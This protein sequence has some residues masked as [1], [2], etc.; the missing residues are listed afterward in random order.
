MQD[1]IGAFDTIRD[2]FIRYVETAFRTKFDDIENRRHKL[3][4]QDRVLYRQP[5]AEPLPEYQGSGSQIKREADNELPEVELADVLTDH[6]QE[7]FRGLVKAGLL[8]A[9]NREL[10]EHQVS[11]LRT[12]LQG[13]H[14]VIT[15]GTGSGKT[16]SFLL[17][18][19]A[20]LVKEAASWPEPGL[21]PPSAQAWW[22]KGAVGRLTD[23]NVVDKNTP[24]G[25]GTGLRRPAQQRGHEYV[26]RE[27]KERQTRPAAVRALILYPMNALVEDQMTRLRR[28]LDSD[29][30]RTWFD[31]NVLRNRIYFGRYTGASP[32]SGELLC[33]DLETGQPAINKWKLD[34]LRKEL[35]AISGNASRIQQYIQEQGLDVAGDA[36]KRARAKE[37][38]AY[39][40]RA[41]EAE[42]RSRFDMQESP[43][44]I[45]IT[46]YSMLSIML[47]RELD[48]PIFTKTRD[49]LAGL[50]LPLNERAAAKKI[51]VFHLIVDEL[52]LYRGTSGTE[53][54]YLLRMVLD[55]LGLDPHH[56]QL[57]ILASSASLETGGEKELESRRFLHDFF[58]FPA[59]DEDKET[60]T[61]IEGQ[62]VKVDSVDGNAVLPVSAFVGL[63]A[64]FEQD[65]G[66]PD[67]ALVAAAQALNAYSGNPPAGGS[68]LHQF[69]HA[70]LGEKLQMRRR[71]Y[72]ACTVL[73][74]TAQGKG[75]PKEK[76]R[77]VPVIPAIPIGDVLPEGF[78]HLAI[79]L[80]GSGHD[81][82]MLRQAVRGLFIGRGL[83]DQAECEL[84]EREARNAGRA[85][86]RFRFHFFFRNIE[87]LWAALPAASE[88]ENDLDRP[89]AVWRKAFGKLYPQPDLRAKSGQHIV[90]SLYCDNCGSVFYGGSRLSLREATDGQF[91]FQMLTVSPEIEGI[92]EKTAEVLV[93][94]RSYR[95][96]AVFWPEAGQQYTRHERA[97]GVAWGGGRT[98]FPWKQ[99]GIGEQRP[100]NEALWV[101]ATIDSRSGNVR[102][103]RVEESIGDDGPDWI[104]GRIFSVTP[105]GG[106]EILNT[107]QAMPAVCPACGISHEVTGPPD[108]PVGRRKT[109]SVRGF[110]TGFAQTSQT[111][112]KE[113]MMQLPRDVEGAR[114]LVLFSDSREDAAQAA[115][116]IERTHYKFLLR[117]LVADYLLH[118]VATGKRLIAA[119]EM[120]PPLPEVERQRLEALDP[121]LYDKIDLWLSDAGYSGTGPERV[122]RAEEAK[123]NLASIRRAIISVR[124]LTDDLNSGKGELVRRFL[125]LGINPGGNARQMQEMPI[126][127]GKGPW[128]DGVEFDGPSAPKWHGD[129]PI[130][131]TRIR[132]ELAG[133]L[134][135]LLFR[136]LFYSLEA[137]GLGIVRVLAGGDAA[138]RQLERLRGQLPAALREHTSDILSS[139]IRILGDKYRYEPGGFPR[140]KAFGS[141]TD[142]A[143]PV[144][145]YIEAVLNL[146]APGSSRDQVLEDI[147]ECLLGTASPVLDD[148]GNAQ[149][150]ELW[151]E[152]VTEHSPAWICSNCKR[153][154]LHPAAGVCTACRTH[155]SPATRPDTTC[156]SLWSRNYLAYHAALQ[157]REAIRLH[158]EELTGQTDDQ[159]ERQRHFRDVVLQ[160]EGPANVR[161]IDLLSVTTTLEVGVDIGA[162]QA[163]MLA[164]M[165]PQRFN[166]Q[167]RVGRAG[168]R[169]QAYSVAFT[170]CRGRSH[171]EFYFANPHKITGDD[172]PV[173]FLATDQ[174]RILR[175]VLAK[176]VLRDVFQA[177][178]VVGGGIHGEFGSF[179]D[180]TARAAELK[181]RLANS[182]ARIEHL[183]DLFMPNP[184]ADLR[185][186]LL[187]WALSQGMD[188]LLQQAQAVLANRSL[189]GDTPSEKLAQG[190]IL[191]MFG[192]PTT[193][194]DLL[195]GFR[196]TGRDK[197]L[198][199]KIDRALD[200]AI[201][202]FAPGAQKMK[203]KVV[204]QAIG[205][206]SEVREHVEDGWRTMTNKTGQDVSAFTTRKWMLQC[207]ECFF[208]KTYELDEKPDAVCPVETCGFD[209]TPADLENGPFYVFQ[210]ASPRAFRTAYTGGRDEREM[211]DSLG[212]RPPLVAEQDSK[213]VT[214]P[215]NNA[216]FCLADADT[217]WR[218]N[219]GPREALFRGRSYANGSNTWERPRKHTFRFKEQWL[220][221]P[222]SV[223]NSP[224]T[225]EYALYYGAPG[226]EEMLALAANKKT[227]ILR[228]QPRQVPQALNLA[229]DH[230]VRG[231]QAHGLKAAYYSAAF[232]LQRAM[233][234][235]LD[236]EPAE[237]EIAGI[238]QIQL[239]DKESI[240]YAGQIVL[241][242]A[243]PNGSGFVR[244]M[245][246]Q[247]SLGEEQHSLLDEVLTPTEVGS[248]L[249][250]IQE[251]KHIK[252]DADGVNEGCGSACYDCLKGYRNM[253]YHA[254]LDWRLALALL[255]IMNKEGYQAGADGDFSQLE[256]ND[257]S[258]Y[259][260]DWLET[261]NNSLGADGQPLGNVQ[262]VG[263]GEQ[264]PVLVWGPDTDHRVAVVVHPFWDLQR[265]PAGNWLSEALG[266]VYGLAGPSGQ[267]QFLD[268]FNL[269]RR[270]GKCYEWLINGENLI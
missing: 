205:F 104:A 207:P 174:P 108:R 92:P 16:E 232:L 262:F 248:Y 123:T 167:Q 116:N 7:L 216:L 178:D 222:T 80:F 166:Y 215:R 40:P 41:D 52:H 39:F 102:L 3:L 151:L 126:G 219:K 54:S 171:D 257:W 38:T 188:G 2:N 132:Q 227:E 86:P 46:N 64:A 180:W 70:L 30:A 27:G 13:K 85:L 56:Q 225:E 124:D 112:A 129:A 15:S 105:T 246:E 31:Q 217:A 66:I 173:P 208:C 157:P 133:N 265:Q 199:T 48:A 197:W 96:Y 229:L 259:A 163:V 29:E 78:Q 249:G 242:D 87:G 168:R 233:A 172:A 159:F 119:F 120:N 212:Q 256:L 244:Q 158:C 79:S 260:W 91:D 228:I 185:A 25:H 23:A 63:A 50:D 169:G 26:T 192:M 58:G 1:P 22:Q 117:E 94:R 218:L 17:P 200:L 24:R 198:P 194:R 32:V 231:R 143:R 53:V 164:N 268:S 88:L 213:Q 21:V 255:R 237:I 34:E 269:S 127:E 153:P 156:R 210:I 209:L 261:F 266:E 251:V 65:K 160:D 121:A 223:W 204:H 191:P 47:M 241:C 84:L 110:R 10:Y 195:L 99:P 82:V 28:A 109:S 214:K 4:H 57:R 240:R 74:S 239:T 193:V 206:T 11:M 6:E 145:D 176:A 203:D 72:A 5:W 33:E 243:L 113:L 122:K 183:L 162:L 254:L 100:E 135:D 55:R 111:F 144:R 141:G 36:K 19:F 118:Q 114:K 12:A 103:G 182:Q 148:A 90:E 59:D 134:G 187:T 107:V 83:L 14:C 235:R 95:D 45:L 190:G 184:D 234:D 138:T 49:W 196:K 226:P 44:D 137:S 221:N 170:F 147:R 189:P 106:D 201:Y 43:P 71:L 230:R 181:V 130:L 136:R 73:E 150:G 154:H 238:T 253:N 125:K 42:M 142:F 128:Y 97:S 161:T 263:E 247:L 76:V 131:Q 155:L 245:H 258:A 60:F 115:N 98:E 18:L 81:P 140:E 250:K 93:E 101:E 165:P 177:A 220:M 149:V 186:S 264:L 77:A 89:R 146:H 37:L 211:S 9:S 35:R 175:R 69:G 51:R 62:Q 267:V 236:V 68:G 270:P 252:G 139:V 224:P 8:D 20:Q 67:A 179:I 75:K 152:A 61:I 202:E